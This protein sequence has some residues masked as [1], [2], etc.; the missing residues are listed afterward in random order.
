MKDYNQGE[1][2]GPRAEPKKMAVWAAYQKCGLDILF[3]CAALA[4]V[5]FAN[6]ID[7]ESNMRPC[8]R[9]LEHICPTAF[10]RQ[11]QVFATD[12]EFS[13]RAHAVVAQKPHM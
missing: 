3:R 1:F 6:V 11:V 7:F 5:F 8:C 9:S 12:V 4:G 13:T 10:G 2:V